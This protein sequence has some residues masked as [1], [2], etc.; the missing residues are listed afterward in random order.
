[1]DTGTLQAV[2][3]AYAPLSL[4]ASVHVRCV[5]EWRPRPERSFLS[6]GSCSH[7]VIELLGESRVEEPT[8][9]RPKA[10]QRR[11][12]TAMKRRRL[13][14]PFASILLL[15]LAGILAK[16]VSGWAE[17]PMSEWADKWPWDQ[18]LTVGLTVLAVVVLVLLIAVVVTHA[19]LLTRPFPRPY[20]TRIREENHRLQD[21]SAAI[22]SAIEAGRQRE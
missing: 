10:P 6:I 19:V 20:P 14:L 22:H 16:V 15:T 13:T 5:S 7:L 9:Q 11:R 4:P 18:I 17:Q 21:I 2:V 12:P 1:M 3:D 8:K